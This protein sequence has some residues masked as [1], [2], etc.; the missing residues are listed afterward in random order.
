M[1]NGQSQ[2]HVPWDKPQ[3]IAPS[4]KPKGIHDGTGLVRRPDLVIWDLKMTLPG[5]EPKT[6]GPTPFG[7]G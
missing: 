3:V 4:P 6:L 2:I 7:W 1:I 5:R